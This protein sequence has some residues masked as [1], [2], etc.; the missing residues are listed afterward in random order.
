MRFLPF[1]RL[2]L[3]V[4]LAAVVFVLGHVRAAVPLAGPV[5]VS[6][7]ILAAALVVTLAGAAVA[8]WLVVA[9]R[10]YRTA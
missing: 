4:V 1:P 7:L 10:P 5:P 9:G 2:S 6:A 8:A 3:G